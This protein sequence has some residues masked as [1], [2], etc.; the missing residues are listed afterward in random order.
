MTRR[1]PLRRAWRG[2]VPGARG[3][4]R[5]GAARAPAARRDRA[6]RGRSRIRAPPDKRSPRAR[7][8]SSSRRPRT[9]PGG[10]SVAAGGRSLVTSRASPPSSSERRALYDRRGR[11]PR[12]RS[13][14]SGA[15]GRGLHV[16]PGSSERLREL[17]PGTGAVE[18]IADAASTHCT[19][20]RFEPESE[21]GL[22]RR[23][24][25]RPGRK[26]R[27]SPRPNASGRRFASTGR[28]RSS[29]SGAG[30]RAT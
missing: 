27:R 10:V 22:P 7:S 28:A 29:R 9:K 23:T 4:H 26:R 1:G 14:R 12:A 13:R 15:R 6:R 5:G 25:C 17:V 3:A 21:L 18:L 24:S 2:R 19:E 8:R 20:L 11:R 30:R 16:E